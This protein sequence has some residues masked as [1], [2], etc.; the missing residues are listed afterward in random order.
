MASIHPDDR[1]TSGR[2]GAKS[3]E[4]FPSSANFRIVR[5]RWRG[6]VCLLEG[7]YE[8]DAEGRPA[9]L[10]GIVHDVTENKQLEIALAEAQRME[11]TK[12]TE[13]ALQAQE[14]ERNNIGQELHDNVNQILVG[15]KDVPGNG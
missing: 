12:L 8:F 5:K 7:R 15:T 3:A 9:T 1:R 4:H 2:T 11:Q 13:T 6:A 14:N 10:F